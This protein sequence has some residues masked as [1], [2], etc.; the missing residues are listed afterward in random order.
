MRLQIIYIGQEPTMNIKVVSEA[1]ELYQYFINRESVYE[2]CG[3]SM[4]GTIGMDR[5]VRFQPLGAPPPPSDD[6]EEDGEWENDFDDEEP[7]TGMLEAQAESQATIQEFIDRS[8]AANDIDEFFAGSDTA[9]FPMPPETPVQKRLRAARRL[10]QMK[11]TLFS[12]NEKNIQFYNR[13][14]R[15]VFFAIDRSDDLLKGVLCPTSV[16]NR[17]GDYDEKQD[18]FEIRK[19]GAGLHTRYDV[20]PLPVRQLTVEQRRYVNGTTAAYSLKEVIA[21]EQDVQL[22]KKRVNEITNRFDILDI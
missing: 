19:S 21:E 7:I 2:D 22:V 8:E 4:N 9:S 15:K 3:V 20:S 5:P 6:D 16:W 17:F 14:V 13:T 11:I 1:E 10:K 18:E 12:L